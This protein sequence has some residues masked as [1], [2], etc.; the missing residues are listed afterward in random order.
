MENRQAVSNPSDISAPTQALIPEHDNGILTYSERDA[1]FDTFPPDNATRV[2]PENYQPS[3]EREWYF[4]TPRKRK[5]KNGDRPNRATV[6]GYWKATGVDKS[7]SSNDIV[8]GFKKVL[9]YYSGKASGGDKT[10]WIMHEYIAKNGPRRPKGSSDM[11]LDDIILCRIYKKAESKKK[12]NELPHGEAPN[13]QATNSVQPCQMDNQHVQ[14][15]VS[16]IVPGECYM[17]FNENLTTE[18]NTAYSYIDNEASMSYFNQFDSF[19]YHRYIP[20]GF[21]EVP[22]SQFLPFDHCQAMMASVSEYHDAMGMAGPRSWKQSS[23]LME[24]NPSLT[25]FNQLPCDCMPREEEEMGLRKVDP[26]DQFLF[27]FEPKQSDPS[28]SDFKD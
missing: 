12:T 13:Q 22:Q 27:N 2:P 15:E 11:R 5:Y 8:V 21:T 7:I 25:Q 17:P 16:T 20:S 4:F 28:N 6:D 3:G 1:Y 14:A 9:V 19:P 23:H 26:R 18:I 24:D 10:S